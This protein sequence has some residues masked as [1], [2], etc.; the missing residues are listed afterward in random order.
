MTT[1]PI[2]GGVAVVTHELVHVFRAEDHDVAALVRGQSHSRARRDRRSAR[3]L[4]IGQV[5]AAAGLRGAA[6]TQR[7]SPAD[8]R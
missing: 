6:Q 8:R 5:D 1:G 3:A 2:S 4:R 7:R